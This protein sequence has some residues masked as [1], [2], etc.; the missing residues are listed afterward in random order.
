[1]QAAWCA[2]GQVWA[3]EAMGDYTIFWNGAR[4]PEIRRN[5]L[6]TVSHVG[7]AH[8]MLESASDINTQSIQSF[9]LS[10]IA[11]GLAVW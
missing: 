3:H 2:Q 1:M 7:L 9:Q 10:A 6:K 8:E 11:L 4:E 5:Y